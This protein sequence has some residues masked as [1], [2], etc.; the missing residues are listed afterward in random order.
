MGMQGGL[1]PYSSVGDWMRRTD[2]RA[3]ELVF[4]ASRK[5]VAQPDVTVA[6]QQVLEGAGALAKTEPKRSV[7]AEPNA[8]PKEASM[9][10]NQ[11]PKNP[12]ESGTRSS[13]SG[14]AP[15]PLS[16]LPKLR[17]FTPRTL[18][19]ERLASLGVDAETLE[20]WIGEGYLVCTTAAGVYYTT[21]RAEMLLEQLEDAGPRRR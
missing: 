8:T 6:D 4:S 11:T 13:P 21:P 9:G 10:R 3:A 12:L 2:K 5:P 19:R 17:G 7:G 14:A 20:D 15:V 1:K 18:A 16:P